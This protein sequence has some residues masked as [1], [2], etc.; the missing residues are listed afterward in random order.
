MKGKKAWSAVPKP[1]GPTSGSPGGKG[2][3]GWPWPARNT[4]CESR[5]AP[6]SCGHKR[7]AISAHPA[8]K[9]DRIL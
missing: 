5:V 3:M 4:R 2:S 7:A 6:V 9:A 1:P 8:N